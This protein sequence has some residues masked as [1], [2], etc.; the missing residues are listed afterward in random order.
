VHHLAD[1][2]VN[3]YIRV[4]LALTEEHPTIKPYLQDAWAQLPDSA[5]PPHVSLALFLATH[6]RLGTLLQHMEPVQFARTLMHPENGPMTL[7]QLVALY[8]WHGDHHIAHL[9]NY[10]AAHSAP[11]H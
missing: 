1:S 4:K 11:A 9:V 10:R 3:A 8:A 6:V 5:L 7:D 2:H